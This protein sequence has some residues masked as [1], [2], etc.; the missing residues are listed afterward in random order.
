MTSPPD[1][2]ARFLR[3]CPV[4]RIFNE[5]LAREFYL[6]FLGM[7]LDWQARPTPDGPLYA[8][9]SRAG[10]TLHLSEH[11]GD[12]TPGACVF[13]STEGLQAYHAELAAKSYRHYHPSIV[14]V[15]WGLEMAVTDPFA[16][17][18]RFTEQRSGK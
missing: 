16:N 5:A 9:V 7:A 3:T 4:I 17:R 13:V 11:H 6:G 8:Q 15:P 10:L 12:A 18:L 1:G 2:S 14:P